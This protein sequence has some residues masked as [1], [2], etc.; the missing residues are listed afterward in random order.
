MDLVSS[1]KQLVGSVATE[2]LQSAFTA[3][4]IEEVMSRLEATD[5]NFSRQ[6]LSLHNAIL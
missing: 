3:N 4:E 1:V 2:L 5:K 6:D